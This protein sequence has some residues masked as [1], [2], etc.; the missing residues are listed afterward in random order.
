MKIIMQTEYYG[1]QTNR[2]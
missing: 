2:L 1:V